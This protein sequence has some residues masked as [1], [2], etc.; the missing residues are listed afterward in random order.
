MLHFCG[1]PDSIVTRAKE[2]TEISIISQ[3][4][5]ENELKSEPEYI[6]ILFI[7]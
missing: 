5:I 1:G 7:A 3:E 4:V 6:Y 2:N